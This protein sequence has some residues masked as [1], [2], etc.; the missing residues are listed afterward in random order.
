MAT[1]VPLTAVQRVRE[2]VRDRVFSGEY[3]DGTMLSEGQIAEQLGVSRTPV[4]EAFVQLESLGFLRLYP[5][6]GALVVPVSREEIEAVMETRW[7]IERHGI[8]QAIARPDPSVPAEMRAVCDQQQLYLDAGDLGAFSDVDREFH[9]V[10]VA[11]TGNPI[12]ISLYDSLR[13]RQQRMVRGAITGDA[14]TAA[15]VL[16]EH[17]EIVA[18]IE[19]GKQ[20]K[21]LRLLQEHLERTRLSP[22]LLSAAAR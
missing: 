21:A 15:R 17:R 19:A 16:A 20:G 1:P 18:T 4:R 22:A 5:K 11:A 6:R 10:L 8:E 7:V 12:L 3:A 13:D 2:F 9:R 14:A